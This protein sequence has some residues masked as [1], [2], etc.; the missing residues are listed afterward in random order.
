MAS[1]TIEYFYAQLYD[2][3]EAD[4]EVK[5]LLLRAQKETDNA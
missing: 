3:F 4:A 5:E 2:E 1:G